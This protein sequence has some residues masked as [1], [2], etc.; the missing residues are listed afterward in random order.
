MASPSRSASQQCKLLRSQ[1]TS[2]SPGKPGPPAPRSRDV[3]GQ[4]E[5]EAGRFRLQVG[6]RDSGE[7]QRAGAQRPGLGWAASAL[8]PSCR[9]GGAQP[10]A[11]TLVLAPATPWPLQLQQLETLLTRGEKRVKAASEAFSNKVF[12]KVGDAGRRAG[13]WQ[14]R[15]PVPTR[16]LTALPP[17]SLAATGSALLQAQEAFESCEAI[18]EQSDEMSGKAAAD[19]AASRKALGAARQKLSKGLQQSAGA[20]G[21]AE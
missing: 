13:S 11:Q 19:H 16:L 12:S 17:L 20:G 18:N 6:G 9:R 7:S 15:A 2:P 14:Q 8:T 1:T 21:A 3:I 5:Q 4:P 10:C